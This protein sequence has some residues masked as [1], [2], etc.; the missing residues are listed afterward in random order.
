M[1]ARCPCQPRF[2]DSLAGA[3]LEN[4]DAKEGYQT[5][6]PSRTAYEDAWRTAYSLKFQVPDSLGNR[7]TVD[8]VRKLNISNVYNLQYALIHK[9]GFIMVLYKKYILNQYVISISQGKS[10][11]FCRNTPSSSTVLLLSLKFK[12]WLPHVEARQTLLYATLTQLW[13]SC[14]SKSFLWCHPKKIRDDMR[15]LISVLLLHAHALTLP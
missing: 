11:Y 6:Q 15:G 4:S 1:T 14:L 10:M 13:G 12:W 5:R 7:S 8:E 9:F 3:K 2:S